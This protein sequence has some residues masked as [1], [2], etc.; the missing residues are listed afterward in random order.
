MTETPWYA[1][2]EATARLTQGDLIWDC[3]L[4][5]WKLAPFRVEGAGELEVLESAVEPFKADV[6]VMS[7]ACDLEH[8][9]VRNVALCSHYSL[10]TYRRLW[11]LEMKAQS[12]NPSDKAWKRHCDYIRAGYVWNLSMLNRGAIGELTLEH[13]VVD[14][15]EVYTMPRTLL[16]S[17]LGQRGRHRLQLL[18]PYRDHLSQ[19][20]ARFFMRVG[21]PQPIDTAW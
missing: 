4:L 7:Q 3:P 19:A 20:F 17:L 13:R 5:R 12:Q 14:F 2:V 1:A 16:E 18:S 10:S 9:K 8:D 15:H 6:I 21:L 11:E